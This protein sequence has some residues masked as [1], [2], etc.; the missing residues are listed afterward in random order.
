MPGNLPMSRRRIAIWAVTAVVL[1]LVGGLV[2]VLV[3]R[4]TDD[5]VTTA[6]PGGVG[7]TPSEGDAADGL[8]SE[9]VPGAG[10]AFLAEYVRADGRVV[11]PD[12]G[13]DTVSEG[14]AY[15]ML[16]AAGLGDADTFDSVWTWTQTALQRPDGLL[17]WRWADGRVADPSSASDADLDAARA[18]V[19]AGQRFGRPD[20]TSA[21]VALGSAVLDLETVQTGAGRILLAGQWATVEPYAYNPSYA[22]PGAA[23]VLAGASGDPRWAELAS[24]SRAVTT[25]LLAEAP[26]PPDWAQVHADGSVE[27]M[28]GAQGRGAS[29]RYGYDAARTPIRYAESCDPADRALAAAMAAPLERG[30]D[31]AEL[32]LGGGPLGTGESVVA[33]TGQAAAVAAAGDPARALDELADGNRLAQADRSYYGLAWAALGRMLLTDDALGG[34]PPVTATP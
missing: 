34:C 17:S 29:V 14:Q 18:L 25:A 10:S 16:V 32:D 4:G 6:T 2:G 3:G 1:L 24:G 26:L 28:P 23:A 9:T 8:A 13:G 31:A 33:A 11:R 27:A 5:G 22:S 15:A 20:Y 19:V 30:G 21:G 12:Q 7:A